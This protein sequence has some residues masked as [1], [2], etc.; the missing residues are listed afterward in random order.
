MD[1]AL[2]VYMENLSRSYIQKLI[3]EGLVSLNGEV[4]SSKKIRL[5]PGDRLSV[6]VPEPEEAAHRSRGYT[7]GYRL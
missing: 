2:S 5:E 7:A 1:K 4:C 6:T 3:G